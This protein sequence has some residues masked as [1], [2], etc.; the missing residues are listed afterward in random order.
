[1]KRNVGQIK[2]G[3]LIRIIRQ[4]HNCTNNSKTVKALHV[5]KANYCNNKRS[6][7]ASGIC[8]AVQFTL[9]QLYTADAV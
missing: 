2:I 6:D 3:L 1:M 8:S 4:L 9:Y 5:A 7:F